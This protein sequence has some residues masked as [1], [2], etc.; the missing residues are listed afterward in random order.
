MQTK[1]NR[2]SNK[3]RSKTTRTALIDAARHLFIVK[4]FGETGTPEIVKLANVTR[5]A[6]YHH[7]DG[8]RALFRGVLEAEAADVA[9]SIDSGSLQERTP[10]DALL[11][12]G[13]AYLD[14]MT[15]PGRVRLLLVDGPSILGRAEMAGIDKATSRE[16]L[17]QGL[18]LAIGDQE[19]GI[20]DAMTD[21]ISAV[22][23]QAALAI[24]E[25]QN[26][27][28]YKSVIRRLLANYTEP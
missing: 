8:K 7:F 9:D 27:A 4:G 2:K 15:E 24:S 6:L 3:D 19:P 28:C 16:E 5:G 10:L 18:K 23:D 22:Y 13:D 20:Q 12:G 21:L 26:P 17:R 25:G 1:S 14:A 11:A